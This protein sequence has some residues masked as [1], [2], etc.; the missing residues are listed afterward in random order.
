[1]R[2]RGS[3]SGLI[4]Y[5]KSSGKSD[6]ENLIDTENKKHGTNI[7]FG[8]VANIKNIVSNATE[9]ELFNK[10]GTEKRIFTFQIIIYTLS[11][12]IKKEK[13]KLIKLNTPSTSSKSIW[14][15]KK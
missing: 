12:I 11:R 15:V 3:L 1:M 4:R 14:T 9:F 5:A 10:D 2:Y 7:Q 8:Q 6:L 13:E